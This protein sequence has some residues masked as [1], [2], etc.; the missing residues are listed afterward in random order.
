[1]KNTLLY[2]WQLPQH[3]IALLLR[4]IYKG[5]DSEYNGCIV[6]RSVYL[7]GGISLGKYIIVNQWFKEIDIKHEYGHSVQSRYLG[8]LYLLVVGL[9]SLLW[10]MMYGRAIR[11]SYNGYYK[12]YTEKWADKL[13]GVKR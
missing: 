1:M 4:L 7:R 10:A 11:L 3:L 8:W 2:L 9:P 12:F 13:G 6:R 5:N